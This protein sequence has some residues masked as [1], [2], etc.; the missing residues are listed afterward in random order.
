MPC[1]TSLPLSLS[2]ILEARGGPLQ[3]LEI[4]ALLCQCAEALQDLIIKGDVFEHEAFRHMVTPNSLLIRNN[5]TISLSEVVQNLQGSLYMAPEFDLNTYHKLSDTAFEKMFVYSVSRTLQVASEFGLK[6]NEVLSISYDLNSLLQAM[7]A[8]NA[9]V[10]LSLMHIL[11][12]CALQSSQHPHKPPHMY[13]L[14]RLYR[15]VLGSD[16]RLSSHDLSFESNTSYGQTFGTRTGRVRRPRPHVRHRHENQRSWSRSRSR[17]RSRSPSRER[18]DS[19]ILTGSYQKSDVHP[20]AVSPHSEHGLTSL[21]NTSMTSTTSDHSEYAARLLQLPSY[22]AAHSVQGLLGLRQGN[23]AYQKYIQLKERQIRLRQA[24]SGKNPSVLDGVRS[25]LMTPLMSHENMTETLS[26]ASLMSYTLGSYKPGLLSQFGSHTA[27]NTSKDTETDTGSHISLFNSGDLGNMMR[28]DETPAVAVSIGPGWLKAEQKQQTADHQASPPIPQLPSHPQEDSSLLDKQPSAAT[29]LHTE[30]VPAQKPK[31]YNGPE[32][33]HYEKKP[34]IKIILPHQAEGSRHATVAR[35]V[36]LVHLTGQKFEV[37][38]DPSTTGRQL[39]DAIIPN[40]DL[41]DFYFFGFT[42]ISE[43]EHIFLDAETKLHKVAPDGWKEGPKNLVLPSTF[44]LYVRVKFYPDSLTDFRHTSS[45]HLLYLQLRRDVVEDRVSCSSDV[46]AKLAGLALQVE[47]GNYDEA[48]MGQGYFMLEHYFPFIAVKHFGENFLYR[49]AVIEHKNCKGI[50]ESQAEIEYIKHVRHLPEYGVHFYRLFRSKSNTDSF[51]WV[52]LSQHSLIIA[53]PEASGR[54]IIQD[55]PWGTILKISF[56]KRRFSIQPKVEVVKG[57]PPKIN[58]YTNSFKK[59]RYLLQFSTEQHRFQLRMRTRP[60]NMETLAGDM[61]V[62]LSGP[63]TVD[64]GVGD[65]VVQEEVSPPAY[66]EPSLQP[67]PEDDWD[68]DGDVMDRTLAHPGHPL[69][70]RSPPPYQAPRMAQVLGGPSF[71]SDIQA[72]SLHGSLDDISLPSFD[73]H[74]LQLLL[75]MTSKSPGLDF[76]P[77]ID[78]LSNK[79]TAPPYP[80]PSDKWKQDLTLSGRQ[81]FEVTLEKEEQHGIGLTIVGGE[82]TNSLDLGIFVKSIVPGGPAARDAKIMAGDRLI[83]IGGTSLEGKQHH[84]AVELIRT[85]GPKVTL[86]I[87]QIRPPGTIKKRNAYECEE[88]ENGEQMKNAKRNLDSKLSLDSCED[89][90]WLFDCFLTKQESYTSDTEYNSDKDKLQLGSIY[91]EHLNGKTSQLNLKHV[92]EDNYFSDNGHGTSSNASGQQFKVS[93]QWLLSQ[94]NGRNSESIRISEKNIPAGEKFGTD[95][96]LNLREDEE[97]SYK[98]NCYDVYSGHYPRQDQDDLQILRDL[99]ALEANDS[100]SDSDFDTAVQ[101]TIEGP[102]KTVLVSKNFVKTSSPGRTNAKSNHDVGVIHEVVLDKSDGSMGIL[103]HSKPDSENG[104]AG[105]YILKILSGSCAE[106]NGVLAAGDKILEVA[107]TRV[108][109]LSFHQVQNMLNNSPGRLVLKVLHPTQTVTDNNGI[110]SRLDKQNDLDEKFTYF[111][112]PDSLQKHQHYLQQQQVFEPIDR[113]PASDIVIPKVPTAAKE[114]KK[115]T[116]LPVPA[117]FLGESESNTQSDVDSDVLDSS[118]S[119]L[120]FIY[121]SA[122]LSEQ[123]KPRAQPALADSN[124]VHRKTPENVLDGNPDDSVQYNDSEDFNAQLLALT[125]ALDERLAA[126]VSSLSTVTMSD[127]LDDSVLKKVAPKGRRKSLLRQ[128]KF[129]DPNAVDLQQP[130]SSPVSDESQLDFSDL[131]AEENLGPEIIEVVLQKKQGVGFGFTVAGGV[132]TGGCY[133]KQLVSEPAVSDGRL[134]PGDKILKVNGQDTISMGH[135]EAVTLLRNVPL[136]ARLQLLRFPLSFEILERKNLRRSHRIF[137]NPVAKVQS[138]PLSEVKKSV[139]ELIESMDTPKAIIRPYDYKLNKSQI[140]EHDSPVASEERNSDEEPESND[141]EAVNN[142]RESDGNDREPD[143]FVGGTQ[144]QVLVIDLIKPIE[145][146][147]NSL[148]ISI[149]HKTIDGQCGIFVK[150]VKD[151]GTAARDG[152]LKAGDQ[153]LEVNGISFHES[154]QKQALSVLREAKDKVVLSV[155]RRESDLHE[156]ELSDEEATVNKEEKDD[157]ISLLAEDA[158]SLIERNKDSA[159]NQLKNAKQTIVTIEDKAI[160]SVRDRYICPRK[161]SNV[162][163]PVLLSAE[164]LS[165]L[166]PMSAPPQWNKETLAELFET[167]SDMVESGEPVEEFKSLHQMKDAGT[168]EVAKLEENRIKNRYRNV[169]PCNHISMEVG[170]STL[171]YIVS[172]GPV[173]ASVS[174]FW[175]MLWQEKI[176]VVVMLTQLVEN[177]KVKCHSYWPQ[178]KD[179][180]LDADEGALRVKLTRSYN[181]DGL[182]VRQMTIEEPDANYGRE[183]TLLQYCDWPDNGVPDTALPLMQLLQ[184]IHLLEQGSP[185]VI[186]C[187]AGIGRTGTLI[188]MDVALATIEQALKLDMFDIVHQLRKQRHGMIQT[189]EQYIFYYGACMEALLSLDLEKKEGINFKE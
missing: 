160:S 8:R 130:L 96:V 118:R 89:E 131:N 168:Y 174:D 100:S 79:D 135:V 23:P 133:I 6:E 67:L 144:R 12:A 139:K 132:N 38:L 46:L 3:E 146:P 94:Q 90:N 116:A 36:I 52:G 155:L 105:I 134:R 140:Q 186:H 84:E 13:T 165:D 81:I 73:E 141:R 80:T 188:A 177:G 128:N 20:A 5:G 136:E 42:Y 65:D 71:Y 145:N 120:E 183:I 149:V 171:R 125:S 27:F 126:E 154:S 28:A 175:R 37:L 122:E 47:F 9:A 121:K 176:N 75:D 172:Q 185:P 179:D 61:A 77:V 19:G 16:Q 173:P 15:S 4:W 162:Y 31:D 88:Q 119:E 114:N 58:F 74:Q 98:L 33:F 43:G 99:A 54:S 62:E 92:L 78:K 104:S 50:A 107:G 127:D 72:Y 108:E 147:S 189:T 157:D 137:D 22:T 169:L 82:T 26:M 97:L 152:R 17:S 44:T 101:Q 48:E 14:S 164:W 166:P 182:C 138:F 55:H 91:A 24:R 83:A 85:G 167:L 124:T 29:K 86:L 148:G 153:I 159:L 51:M 103:A 129:D 87:S 7:S 112:N 69:Q 95:L 184:L 49:N 151:A 57:K 39:F 150:S 123:E 53:E 180:I 158:L 111:K 40:L 32:Y 143:S 161:L 102:L 11:E 110:N 109:G 163:L 68:D 41:D 59:G 142:D 35:R 76:V 117:L 187:S 66:V 64:T 2:E 170:D 25:R 178:S 60:S 70:Y 56:N 30:F 113:A 10:R 63:H 181:V 115:G 106:K 18:D 45:Y 34:A 1:L 156:F 21:L 93:E